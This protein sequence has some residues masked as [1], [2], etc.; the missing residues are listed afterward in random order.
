M[1]WVAVLLVAALLSGLA[2]CDRDAGASATSGFRNLGKRAD[3]NLNLAG[4]RNATH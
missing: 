1:R 2:G 3:S 4:E